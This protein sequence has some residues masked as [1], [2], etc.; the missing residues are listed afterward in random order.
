MS[1]SPQSPFLICF[2]EFE[3]RFVEKPELTPR[4]V[5]GL[6]PTGLIPVVA[7]N[8][9]RIFPGRGQVSVQSDKRCREAG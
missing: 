3:V 6:M 2:L 8:R 9:Q 5:G 7:C 1:E 4:S